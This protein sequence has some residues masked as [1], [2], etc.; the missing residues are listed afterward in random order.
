MY[1]QCA[2]DRGAKFPLRKH[3]LAAWESMGLKRNADVNSGSPLGINGM[4]E[5]LNDGARQPASKVYPLSGVTVMTNTIV[6]NIVIESNGTSKT[7][8]GV[9]LQDGRVLL[10]SKEVILSAGSIATPKLLLL[11]GI[12][13]ARDLTPHGIE[14]IVDLP[15]VGTNLHNHFV[16]SQ[17]WELRYPELGLAVGSPNFNYEALKKG[18]PGDWNMVQTVDHEGM[19]KALEKDGEDTTCH[20]LLNP[21]RAHTESYMIYETSYQSNPTRPMGGSHVTT[22]IMALLPT[23][24][25]TVK[26]ASSDPSV[27]PLY[28]PNYYST[29]A[30][31]F[32]MRSALRQWM[33]V[34]TETEEGRWMVKGIE[35]VSE[36]RQPLTFTS[37]DEEIDQ[38][39]RERGR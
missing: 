21:P 17:W 38:L 14:Q 4:V 29:E 5:N 28:D 22:S 39:V 12:G 6:T 1:T 23:S 26:L 36:D 10:A 27:P 19:K 18:F 31:R 32:V 8:K 37:S 35:T 13:A 24:R 33:Q 30:D 34:L 9:K 15:Q 20:V 16:V 3:V 2:A 11:S 7:A 25:G